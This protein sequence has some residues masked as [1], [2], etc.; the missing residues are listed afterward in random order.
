MVPLCL[1]PQSFIEELKRKDQI[2]SVCHVHKRK[3]LIFTETGGIIICNALFDY[4]VGSYG[5][6]FHDGQ[7]LLEWLNTSEVLGYYNSIG[8]YPSLA[9]ET[10]QWYQDCG[11]GCPLRWAL[12]KP[13]D[14]I[15]PI[16]K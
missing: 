10:C 12:Y 7:S 6:D 4:P 16:V 11:G 1:W 5:D 15:Q 8:C 14:I 13:D 3:G 2:L 9:C